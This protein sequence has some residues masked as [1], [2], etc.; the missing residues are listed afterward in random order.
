MLYLVLPLPTVG[1][2]MDFD[3]PL[4]DVAQAQAV[5]LADIFDTLRI[6]WVFS[7]PARRCLETLLPYIARRKDTVGYL[8]C[9]ADYRL[10]PA[11]SSPQYAARA[12]TH[13]DLETF[14]LRVNDIDGFMVDPGETSEE[15]E[16][17]VV[18][19]FTDDLFERY[20]D[21]PVPTIVMCDPLVASAIIH[22]LM[23]DVPAEANQLVR[24]SLTPGSVHEFGSDGFRLRYM[25][26]V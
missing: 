4:T 5:Q 19:Y 11:V 24:N 6:E 20:R 10:Y 2:S 25:R 21:S 3:A 14:R 22:Y 23:Q 13:H 12:L 17:R 1:G 18:T 15:F 16:R 9:N 26:Q 8:R 7:C